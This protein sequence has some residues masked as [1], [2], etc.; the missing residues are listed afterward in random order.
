[1]KKRYLKHR[2]YLHRRL[3][4]DQVFY[5]GRGQGARYLAFTRGRSQA[6]TA[7][8]KQ[9]G[10]RA[11]VIASYDDEHTAALHE[12]IYIGACRDLGISLVNVKDG[13]FDRNH[14]CARS[15]ACRQKISQARLVNNGNAKQVRTPLG[16]FPSMA[17]A[18]QAHDLSLDQMY[19]RVRVKPGF[20]L[21]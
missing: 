10:V 8:W 3:D 2:V 11:E 21:C 9:H 20:E 7:I 5:V 16:I 1:M 14:G 13:G 6:W 17:Q 4:T 12:Q 18:A 15:V 19:Y